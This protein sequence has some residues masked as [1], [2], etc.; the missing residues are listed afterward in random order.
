MEVGHLHVALEKISFYL[1]ILV[2][3]AF[4]MNHQLACRSSVFSIFQCDST[5]CLVLGLDGM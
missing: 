2:V 4:N 5:V 1:F 3:H